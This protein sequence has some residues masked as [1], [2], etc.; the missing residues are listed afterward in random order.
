MYRKGLIALAIVALIASAP[1]FAGHG[2]KCKSSTQ[3]CLNAMASKMK[4]SGWVGIEMDTDDHENLVIVR[5][6]PGSPAEE[7]GL[8]PGDV[9]FA[10]EGVELNYEKNEAALKKARKDWTPGQSVNYTIKRDGRDKDIE[11]TLAPMPADV[12]AKWVGQHM[13]EHANVEIAENK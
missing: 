3:D 8:K 13:L 2:K 10:L 12:L 4:K 1:A 7:A 6:V 9:L 5:V 11:L